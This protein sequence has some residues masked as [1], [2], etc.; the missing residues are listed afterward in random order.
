MREVTDV[1]RVYRTI[2]EWFGTDA[3]TGGAL[4]AGLFQLA[5]RL[6]CPFPFYS[7]LVS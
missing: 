7:F 3:T 4:T 2:F 6:W 1:V 5:A